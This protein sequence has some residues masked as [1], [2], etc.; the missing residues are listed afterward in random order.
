[1]GDRGYQTQHDANT[2]QTAPEVVAN[3]HHQGQAQLGN[4]ELQERMHAQTPD[5]TEAR[6]PSPVPANGDLSYYTDR[7]N[8][9]LER[10]QFC[11]LTPPVY[12]LGYGKKYVERFTLETHDRLTPEGQQ[13]LARTRVLLQAAIEE[14]READPVAFDRLERNDA[15][16]TRFAYDSHPDAY[17]DAGLGELDI[18]DLANIG[19]TPDA[20]D[21]FAWDGI[22]QAADIGGRL[23]GVWGSDAIDYIYGEGS[24]DMAL[25]GMVIAYEELGKE[26]DGVFGSGTA[27]MLEQ[28]MVET[29]DDIVNI[30]QSLHGYASDAAEAAIDVSDSIFGEGATEN[31]LNEASEIA[32]DGVDWVEERYRE[33]SGWANDFVNWWNE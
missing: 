4:A 6:L 30:G 27:K 3:P 8:D 13:W 24:A 26:I 16:F 32:S 21:L 28:T 9:F 22:V 11:G 20:R 7:H 10:Y 2:T 25:E 12:Y 14:E 5:C 23:A 29:A 15:A 17:W 31:A 1:M 18:F 33:A 19:L